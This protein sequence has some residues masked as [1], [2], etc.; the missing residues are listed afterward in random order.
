MAEWDFRLLNSFNMYLLRTFNMLD[1]VVGA[2]D[3]TMNKK[4]GLMGRKT[5]KQAI[6]IQYESENLDPRSLVNTLS[7]WASHAPCWSFSF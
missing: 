2:G 5:S 4:L 7:H 1:P 3:A 6:M